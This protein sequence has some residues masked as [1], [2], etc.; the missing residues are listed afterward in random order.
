M[1]G[2]WLP[3]M[4]GRELELRGDSGTSKVVGFRFLP[5]EYAEL[6]SSDDDFSGDVSALV[7]CFCILCATILTRT[8]FLQMPMCMP[9]HIPQDSHLKAEIVTSEWQ[10]PF[11]MNND[12]CNMVCCSLH[13]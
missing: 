3:R 13:C 10:K 6:Y 11:S 8:P 1:K 5:E 12:F 7:L 2:V 9:P 4:D